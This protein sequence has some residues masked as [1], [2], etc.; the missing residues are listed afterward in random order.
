[1]FI[2][3]MPKENLEAKTVLFLAIR[4][5]KLMYGAINY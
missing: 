2:I 5:G 3:L 1:M 4:G